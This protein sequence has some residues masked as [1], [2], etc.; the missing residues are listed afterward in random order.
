MSDARRSNG[1]RIGSSAHE[2]V[3]RR[4]GGRMASRDEIGGR[5]MRIG[6]SAFAGDGGKSGISQYM[7][8]VLRRL[9]ELAP[10]DEFVLFM[11]E[12]DRAFLDLG[13]PRT[14]IVCSPDWVAHPV[15]NI[16]WHLVWLP[17]QLKRHGCDCV[18]MPAG[19][20]RLSWRYGVPSVG[21]VH[22]LSQLHLPA[23]YDAFR[24][25]YVL[26][27]L[28]H[29]MRRLTRVL[30]VSES[31][32]KDLIEYAR[33]DPARI[34]VVHNGADLSCYRPGDKA[35]ARARIADT[36]GFAGPYVLYI[37]RL[38]HPGKNHVRLIAAFAALKR[39]HP[40]LAHKLV[41]V[42]S[43][44][45]G[46]EA[47]DAAVARYGMREQVVFPGFVPN[48]ALCDLYV[49]AD[50]FVFPSLYEGFGIPVLEAM[51]AGTPVCASNAS[52]IPEVVGDA[53]L[54]FDPEREDEI[55]QAMLRL[56]TDEA[57]RARCVRRGLEQAR[58]FSWDHSAQGVLDLCH[59]AVRVCG[60]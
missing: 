3:P 11:A 6:I 2:G 39:A 40:E 4:L 35:E 38:E 49:G 28:P 10:A 46:A 32:R 19:N 51:A 5:A 36:L 29:F 1:W 45:N 57:L 43:R 54:L 56:L 18:F 47:I 22:D 48:E 37:A 44:W 21:T 30:S 26:R 34:R 15:L 20:R 9:P 27:V 58:R 17:V 53:G 60:G 59:E 50:V 23:K 55:T 14:R 12:S 42:G 16:L 7:I 52:S 41:L 8:Q 33:V 25:F 24:M 13:M 31:T